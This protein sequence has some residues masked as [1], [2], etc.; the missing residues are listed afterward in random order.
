MTRAFSG[1]LAGGAAGVFLSALMVLPGPV[2]VRS[3]VS[4]TVCPAL[5]PVLEVESLHAS[6]ART[7]GERSTACDRERTTR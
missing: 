3:L 6:G 2:E 7:R 1:W 4:L 5:S